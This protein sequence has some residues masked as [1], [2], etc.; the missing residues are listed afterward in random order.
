MPLHILILGNGAAGATA[1]R[2]ARLADPSARITVVSD[3]ALHPYSRPALMYIYTGQLAAA[4][5]RLY[6]DD[7]WP[8]NRIDLIH[9]R[10]VAIDAVGHTV[11]LRDAGLVSFDRLLIA[12]GSL[13]AAPAWADCGLACV[14]GFIRLSDLDRMERE[15]A[16]ASRAV[17]VGGGLIGV[18]LAEMLRSRGTPVTLL[19]REE[20]YCANLLPP[21]E[22]RLVEAEIRRH[23]VDLRLSTDVLQLSGRNGR[24][25]TVATS[26][27]EVPASWVGVATGVRPDVDVSISAGLEV[28]VGVRVDSHLRTSAADVFAAGDC[29]ELREPPGGRASIEA[30]WYVAREQGAI[31]GRNMAG[32]DIA[33][34]PGVFYNSA[35]FFD[36]EWQQYGRIDPGRA[37]EA[38][39]YWEDARGRRAL[40]IQHKSGGEVVG[41]N[42]IGIR[43][44]HEVCAGWIAAALDVDAVLARLREAVFDE[45]LSRHGSWK[46]D[47]GSWRTT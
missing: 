37:D 11:K 22:G 10:A 1:A 41:F 31:A 13:T 23:G 7:F 27:G 46:M 45:E 33:Y 28:N 16:G 20:T 2:F 35:K 36:L 6:A 8:R 40:R 17:V 47:H 29:A 42:A 24:V 43:L 38:S 25:A 5:T 39:L 4:Q 30:L 26:Y 34:A 14:Q 18:E 12:T 21:E 32:G 15:A 44:R 19:V 3:E 9:D